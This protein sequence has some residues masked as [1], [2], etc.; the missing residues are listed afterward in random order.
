MT[1]DRLS[2]RRIENLTPAVKRWG[3]EKTPSARKTPRTRFRQVMTTV[4]GVL[5][6]LTASAQAQSP[7]A[8]FPQ[9]QAAAAVEA[10]ALAAL[11]RMG[12]YLRTLK[13]FQVEA[14]TTSEEV[15]DDGQ[16]IKYAGVVNI[17]ARFPDRLRAEVE[18]DRFSR[19][20]LYDGKNFTLW[21]RRVNYYAT[22]AA[23]KTIGLL[24][25]LL[26][27]QYGIEVPL[28]DLFLWG[29]PG[30]KSPG[31]SAALDVGPSQVGGTTCEQYA[32]RQE[33]LDWQVWIQRGDYPL[34]RKLVITSLDDEARPQFTAVYTWNLA[35]SFNEA[36]FTFDPP[37]GAVRV[38]LAEN[39]PAAGAGK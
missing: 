21:A 29:V 37:S 13:A 14:K 2:L 20:F 22:I 1:E 16:K 30:W 35:P 9:P 25:D 5:V 31:I 27:D 28:S 32:F 33:G 34:P 10:G 11:E 38:L 36:A 15:L 3:R 17:V 39:A 26:E 6:V 12:A 8:P 23:P 24:A 4:A 18:N 19:H 7:N